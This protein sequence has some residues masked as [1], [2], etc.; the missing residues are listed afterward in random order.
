MQKIHNLRYYTNEELVTKPAQEE[1]LLAKILAELHEAVDA[2][3][4]AKGEI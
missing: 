2:A 1:A 4:K 3:K